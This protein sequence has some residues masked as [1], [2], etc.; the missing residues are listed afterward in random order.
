[1]NNTEVINA[2][3][4]MIYQIEHLDGAIFYSDMAEGKPWAGAHYYNNADDIRDYLHYAET[5]D[6]S[7]FPGLISI[8]YISADDFKIDEIKAIHD[9][10]R[11]YGEYIKRD[12][13]IGMV[14]LQYDEGYTFYMAHV[15]TERNAKE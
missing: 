13:I 8:S 4:D 1:M 11:L 15:K 9:I 3:Q 2:L 10:L 5:K 14:V 12:E 7:D 6:N